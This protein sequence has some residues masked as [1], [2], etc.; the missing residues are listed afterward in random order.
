[1]F[2]LYAHVGLTLGGRLVE[3]NV[4]VEQLNV[5]LLAIPCTSA[6]PLSSTTTPH[7]RS[8]TTY[9]LDND[10][11]RTWKRRIWEL[12]EVG[13]TRAC[14]GDITRPPPYRPPCCK[15]GAACA[16][17][18]PEPPCLNGNDHVS[19]HDGTQRYNEHGRNEHGTSA[20]T[21]SAG[22]GT[23]PPEPPCLNGD[24]HVY[25]EHGR[26]EHGMSSTSTSAGTAPTS[27]RHPRETPVTALATRADE[28]QCGHDKHGHESCAAPTMT[29]RPLW[30]G[31]GWLD[32]LARR[33]RHDGHER[34]ETASM[35]AGMTST[36]DTSTS[37][38]NAG[39]GSAGASA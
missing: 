7:P 26:N 18:T 6:R 30:E 11:R 38:V 17:A 34:D 8:A 39:T 31:R 14:A 15:H 19:T 33:A 37:C 28:P 10:I 24:G 29:K 5:Q 23:M 13:K 21:T 2:E 25:T 32:E 22:T 4:D 12:D 27:K 36:C 35:G 9:T 1:M 20:S 16:P 3:V